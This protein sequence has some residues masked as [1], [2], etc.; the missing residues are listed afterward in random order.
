MRNTALGP[1]PSGYL[2]TPADNF[3][4]VLSRSGK[5]AEVSSDEYTRGLSDPV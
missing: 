5:S 3:C 4:V 1:P 2:N